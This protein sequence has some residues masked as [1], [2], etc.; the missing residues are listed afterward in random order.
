MYNIAGVDDILTFSYDNVITSQETFGRYVK[1]RNQK[2]I[3]SVLIITIL[4]TF[5]MESL[6]IHTY[7]ANRI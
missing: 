5:L 3:R 1:L 4:N 6:N 7:I 2:S